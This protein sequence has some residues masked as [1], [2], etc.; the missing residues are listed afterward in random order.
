[1]ADLADLLIKMGAKIEGAG[2]S[3]TASSGRSLVTITPAA[4]VAAS[5]GDR[6]KR[7]NRVTCCN[8]C[9]FS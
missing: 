8:T 1:M 4:R 7:A 2:T 3:T 9:R 6:S 5:S